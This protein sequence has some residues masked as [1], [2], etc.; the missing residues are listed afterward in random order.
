[1]CEVRAWVDG[2]LPAVVLRQERRVLAASLRIARIRHR[3]LSPPQNKV[4]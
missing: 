1:M 4:C 2:R 3:H